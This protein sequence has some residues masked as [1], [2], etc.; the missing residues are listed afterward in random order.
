LSDLPIITAAS[1]GVAPVIDPNGVGVFYRMRAP[2]ATALYTA[3]AIRVAGVRRFMATFRIEPFWMKPVVGESLADIPA[4]TQFLLLELEN[5]R[6]GLVVPLIDG[7]ARAVIAGGSAEGEVLVTVETGE[8]SVVVSEVAALFAAVGDDPYALAAAAAK[9]VMAYLKTGRRREEKPL[10]SFVDHFGWCTWDAFYKEVNQDKVR[11]GLE[12]FAAGGVSPRLLILDDGWQSIRKFESG[13]ER[14]TGFSANDKF[15]GGLST[16][17]SMA[18]DEF[19]VETFLVWHAIGG[20][21]G[22]VDGEALTGYGVETVAR[23]YPPA[24]DDVAVNLAKWFGGQAGVV[25]PEHIYRFYQDYHRQLRLQGV[26]GIKVDNQSSIESTAAGAGRGRVGMMR[27]YREALEGSAAVQ[28]ADNGVPRLINCM[29][30]SND[31][32]YTALSSNLTRT[33]TDFWPNDPASHGLHLYVNATVGFWFG[34]FIHPDW[35]MFQSGHP[36]GAFHAAGRAVSGSP[37]YVSDKP[38]RHDFG[39]LRKLVLPDGSVLR[40]AGPGRPTRDLL[41]ADPTRDDVLLKIFNHNATGAVV[42]VFN[43]RAEQKATDTEPAVA[44]PTLT[45]D[46]RPADVPGLVG[47]RFVAYAHYAQELRPIALDEAW[48]VTLEPLTAE[49]LTFVLVDQGVAVIGL[50]EMLNGGGAVQ[51]MD[52]DRANGSVAA[53]VRGGGTLLAWCEREPASVSVD[54]APVTVV[55]NPATGM[56]RIALPPSTTPVRVVIA[57]S[58]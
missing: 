38:G 56:L 12:S 23:E 58:R 46:V 30:C 55:Y 35:D 57:A 26:D 7:P 53:M 36:M 14:L 47:D 48:P 45:G 54:G 15:P 37:V 40:C 1:E 28:F 19:S 4:E 3:P 44:A 27:A 41:F 18:K 49:I 25:P 10:P 21:W 16:T 52:A 24:L 50:A 31:M 5:G 22:G 34:E 9:S 39:L 29:S 6:I 43:A 51:T 8:S 17:V 20:Y 11:E 33:S 42:G 32:M 13:E 2:E